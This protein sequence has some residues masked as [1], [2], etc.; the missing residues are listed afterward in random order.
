MRKTIVGVARAMAAC[1]A[2][3]G[4]DEPFDFWPDAVFSLSWRL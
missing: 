1:V 3:V 4:S 2:S